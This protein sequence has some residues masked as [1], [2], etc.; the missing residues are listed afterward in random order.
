MLCLPAASRVLWVGEAGNPGTNHLTLEPGHSQGAF[1]HLPP[2]PAPPPILWTPASPAFP[3]LPTAGRME[4]AGLPQAKSCFWEALEKL[5][6][7]LCFLCSLV[8]YALVGA[9]VFS[10]IEGS[11]DLRAEDP[12]FEE[13]L[14]KL[15]GILKCNS[16]GR[17]LTWWADLF[18]VGGSSPRRTAGL[19]EA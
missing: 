12:E 6:P 11:Q 7:R 14:E 15:C 5:F 16:T 4:A 2:P 1:L 17:W 8:T 19:E 18:S 10:A 13:F 9:A 3:V